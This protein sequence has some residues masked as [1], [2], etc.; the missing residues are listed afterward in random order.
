M[1]AE[2]T[3][4]IES[5]NAGEWNSLVGTDNPFLRHEF[6]AAMESSGCV[7]EGTG[8]YP[9]HVVL[10]DDQGLLEGAMPLY[11]KANS[12]G[13][14]VF[15]FAWADAY[16]QAGLHYYPKLV[17]AIPYTPATGA[18][19]LVARERIRRRFFMPW[20]M[21]LVNTL[22]EYKRHLYMCYFQPHRKS[23]FWNRKA[24]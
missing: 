15:D 23:S 22:N 13:E 7:G 11:R 6:L 2:I 8:W 5:V 16:R 17:S 20:S 21:R 19:C 18:R 24:C 14:F 3:D 10:Y 4:A 1:G 9:C 12:W